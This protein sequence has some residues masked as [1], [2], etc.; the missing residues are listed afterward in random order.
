[1]QKAGLQIIA[2]FGD[3]QLNAYEA[4]SSNR[5]IL[6]AQKHSIS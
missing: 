3:Y 1:M 6:V 4:S 2:T 5:L